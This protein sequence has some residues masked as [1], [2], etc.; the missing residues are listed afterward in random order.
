MSCH[1]FFVGGANTLPCFQAAFGK[2]VRR[3]YAAHNLYNNAN[4][5]IVYDGFKIVNQLGFDWVAGKF[6]QIQNV[7]DMDLV[8]CP[9]IDAVLV[10]I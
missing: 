5:R 4:L 7:F 2:G 6:P 9:A 10:G 1:Q 3:L 8:S